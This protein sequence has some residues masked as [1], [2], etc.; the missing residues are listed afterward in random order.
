ML[1]A[2]SVVA[3]LLISAAAGQAANRRP[4][5]ITCPFLVEGV[6]K[7]TLPAKTG[8][9]PDIDFDYA[10]KA[11]LFSFRDGHLL[12]VAM[13][14]EDPSRLR[15]VVS[16]QLN[17]AKGT[18]DGQIVTDAGGNQRMID[19]GPVSCTVSP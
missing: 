9:L 5:T 4:V 1:V 13:D 7:I 2:L 16:A 11:T 19:N 12:L 8:E 14:E 15:V 6:V 18:Y 17:K 10:A 3:G